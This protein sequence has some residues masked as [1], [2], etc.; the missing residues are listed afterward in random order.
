MNE[1]ADRKRQLLAMLRLT[2]HQDF[3]RI[4]GDSLSNADLHSAYRIIQEF[5]DYG[6][7]DR[8]IDRVRDQDA[9]SRFRSFLKDQRREA[10]L[11]SRRNVVGDPE[12]R[13][14]LGVLLNATNRSDVLSLTRAKKPDI[15]PARQVAAWLRQLSGI[16][17]KLQAE[18]SPW[19]PN[20]LGLPEFD[21][22][23]ER[24]CVGFLNGEDFEPNEKIAKSIAQL[25]A[26]PALACLFTD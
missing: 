19:Y 5:C 6:L 10:L 17:L 1:T 26:L 22:E 16:T 2:D 8:L 13:F 12:L 9:A 25:R 14:F 23:I 11:K 15:A 20:I 7:V 3:G 18:G 24:V 21:D 4:T